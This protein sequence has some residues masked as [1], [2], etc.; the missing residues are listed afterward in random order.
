VLIV[1]LWHPDLIPVEIT[2][3]E[4]LHRFASFQAVSLN[5][6]WT[7]NAEARWMMRRHDD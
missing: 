6:Y 7:S 5:R 4:G 3:L 2:Y 1:D